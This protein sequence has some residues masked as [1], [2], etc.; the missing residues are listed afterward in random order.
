MGSLLTAAHDRQP[1][2]S[3]IAGE[4]RLAYEAVKLLVEAEARS[5]DDT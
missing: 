1:F 5:R 4:A 2:I 3:D